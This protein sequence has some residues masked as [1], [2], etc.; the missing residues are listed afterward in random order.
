MAALSTSLAVLTAASSAASF[1]GQRQGAAGAERIGK[2]QSHIYGV[3]AELAELQAQDAIARGREA[4]L[5]H[6]GDVR[7]LVGAQRTRYA[8]QGV[9]LASESVGDVIGNTEMLGELDALTIRQNAMRE[10]WGYRVDASNSRNQ[11]RLAL[12]AGRNQANS[13]RMQSYSTLLSGAAQTY[14]IYSRFR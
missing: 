3:N 9:D 13:M 1:L 8:A 6:R 4:E 5:K 12:M 2:Y 7:R 10:A 11:G 14:D